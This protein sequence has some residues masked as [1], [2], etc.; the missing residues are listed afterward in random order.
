MKIM[1]SKALVLA[2]IVLFIGAGVVP[3]ISSEKDIG[4][5]IINNKT[6]GLTTTTLTFNPTD[7]CWIVKPN[8]DTPNGDYDFISVRNAYITDV[9]SDEFTVEEFTLLGDPSLKLGGYP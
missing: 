6:V 8:P 4:L 3:N 7:D 2:V 5:N 1:L 9:P